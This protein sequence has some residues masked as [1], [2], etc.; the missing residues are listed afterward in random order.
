MELTKHVQLLLLIHRLNWVSEIT[1]TGPVKDLREQIFVTLDPN[2]TQ[3][4][5][6]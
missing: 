6:A 3:A 2:A 1:L 4:P 5:A